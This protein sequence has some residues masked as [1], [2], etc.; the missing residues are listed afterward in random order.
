[1]KITLQEKMPDVVFYIEDKNL[2][3]FIEAVTSVGPMDPKRVKEIEEMTANVT[4]TKVYITAFPD[5]KTFKKF[6]TFL[7]WETAVWIADV[8]DHMIHLNGHKFIG[9]AEK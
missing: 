2:L 9:L 1:M 4:A 8:P 3:F 6:V 7:A 5:F